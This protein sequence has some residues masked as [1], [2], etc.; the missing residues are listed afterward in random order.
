MHY[1]SSNIWK[2]IGIS[3]LC[4]KYLIPPGI[5]CRLTPWW[6]HSSAAIDDGW[7]D[8]YWQSTLL[9]PLYSGWLGPTL[10]GCCST[11]PRKETR[12]FSKLHVFQYLAARQHFWK[13]WM[14]KGIEATARNES[15]ICRKIPSKEL[16]EL[17]SLTLPLKNWINPYLLFS[18]LK[19]I[20]F[21]EIKPLLSAQQPLFKLCW[22]LVSV[23]RLYTRLKF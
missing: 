23:D 7:N 13:T 17:R 2:W 21:W 9:L 22:D 19:V 14:S 1:L 10:L 5:S 6:R 20:L 15:R 4:F 3:N 18:S 16:N 11:S 8:K 12:M